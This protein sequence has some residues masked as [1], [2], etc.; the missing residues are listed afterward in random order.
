M[1]RS[2]VVCCMG[3]PSEAQ[4]TP[5]GADIMHNPGFLTGTDR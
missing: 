5:H 1:R 2:V 3:V 4:E